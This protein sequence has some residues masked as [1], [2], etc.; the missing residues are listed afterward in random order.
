MREPVW[1]R[2][3]AERSPVRVN[4]VVVHPRERRFS[5]DGR[6]RFRLDPDEVGS[7]RAW[8]RKAGVFSDSVRVPGCWQGQGHGGD[9]MDVPWD[10]RIPARTFRATYAG[11][12]WYGK[13]F[14]VPA[15]MR[16]ARLWLNFGGVHPSADV[17]LNGRRLGS[18]SGPF[19]PFAFDITDAARADDDNFLVVRVHEALRWLG[20]SYNWQGNWS[21][22][23]RSVEL[24]ATGPAWIERLWLHPDP[25]RESLRV[26]GRVGGE[27]RALTLAVSVRSAGKRNVRVDAPGEFSFDV[28]VPGPKLWS[29]DGPNLYRVDTALRSGRDILD[30]RSERVGFV[31][32]EM[33][34]KQFTINDEPYYM[35]GTG[36]FNVCPETG[37]PD[38]DRARWRRKLKV[39]RDYGYNYVRCQSYVP[40]PEYLDAADEVGLIVQSEM[41]ALG[42]WGGHSIWHVYGWPPPRHPYGEAVREQWDATVMRDV[43]HPSAAIYCMSNELGGSTLYPR[44][45]RECARRT[46][47]IKPSAL[48][49]WTDGGYNADL[50]GEFVNAAAHTD[51]DCPLPVIQHEFRWWSSF[52]DVRTKGKYTGAVRPYAIEIAEREA[53][54]WKLRGLL[55]A[56]A[57]NSQR[58]QFVEAKGKME[59]CR[60]DNATLAGICHFD[61]MDSGYSP[62]GVVDEFYEHK[63]ADAATWR[64]TNGDTVIMMDRGFHERVL[65]GGTELRCAFSVSD[66][67]HPP[68]KKPTIKW[69]L[70]SG[71]RILARGE[72]TYCHRSFRTC[73]AG[74]LK[75]ALP[76]VR[77]PLKAALRATL[78]DGQ[79]SVENEWDFWLM[80]DGAPLPRRIGTYGR[81]EDTWLRT[82]RGVR[83]M[84]PDDVVLTETFDARMAAYV[85]GGGRVLLAVGEGLVRPFV[86]KLGLVEGRYFF[87]PPANYPPYNAGHDG[88]IIVPHPMLGEM[89]HEGLADLQF[90][91]LIGNTPPFDMAALGAGSGEP[92]IR[93]ISTAYVFRPLAYLAEFALGKGGLIIS[94]LDLDQKL[95]EARYLLS[96]I[97]RYAAGDAFAPRLKLSAG[98]LRN[99]RH[100]AA[101]RDAGR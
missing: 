53:A 73:P 57:A 97:L 62:Q 16:G 65:V 37:S 19:V 81:L 46:K 60:R 100:A 101:L 64:R 7:R 23:F 30:A 56:I 68:L 40:A 27:G 99:V 95:P 48:V 54:A 89:P 15:H 77:K 82:L 29:P 58:L 47:A 25:E 66:F 18:H 24:T 21:G 5:L 96:R 44:A 3:P 50:P 22:L 1:E 83:P 12:G 85:R 78:T 33:R 34:G 93:A 4:P 39:L 75:E 79:R 42:A 63:H 6:W 69:E 20:L 74:R 43:N 86:G 91:R 84:R 38:T 35:R 87:T 11:T 70:V 14:R 88:T 36:D 8:Y 41:G 17:W 80:P 72:M 31:H 90:Y 76:S 52:P 92:V 10:F 71:R 51:K 26:S 49:I 55:P 13:R 61:A 45:A 67:S 2:D 98:G 59:A 94:A 9:G 32:F 28:P